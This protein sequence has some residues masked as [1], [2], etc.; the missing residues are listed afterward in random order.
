MLIVRKDNERKIRRRCSGRWGRSRR[1]RIQL[2]TC[3]GLALCY[4]SVPLFLCGAD[5]KV[6][7]S[8]WLVGVSDLSP[9][10]PATVWLAVQPMVS[11]KSVTVTVGTPHDATIS[12]SPT[13][14]VSCSTTPNNK[15]N[16]VAQTTDPL[17]LEYTVTA[18]A[19]GTLR[20]LALVEYTRNDGTHFGYAA[21]SDRM[22]VRGTLE[23]GP[24]AL[25]IASAVFGL[26]AGV[27]TQW[28]ASWRLQKQDDRKRQ[29]DE[30]LAASKL[31]QEGEHA[32]ITGLSVEL[33]K[34]HDVLE[35]YIQRGG[36]P[37]TLA[38]GS[39]NTL[40]KTAI[41]YLDVGSR[42]VYLKRIDAL[43]VSIHEYN[44]KVTT[45]ADPKVIR[46]AAEGLVAALVKGL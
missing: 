30:Q 18:H 6:P 2:S 26:V 4:L 27:L 32:L 29:L 12:V 11:A 24:T 3:V 45:T 36:T 34:N 39:Y 8:Q 42:A 19:T 14:G 25:P 5:E 28:F 17:L 44:S 33:V 35:E 23:I 7:Q 40:T 9:N 43:Y 13:Q 31:Q 20:M 38:V 37:P 41:G 15:I 10:K 22:V 21:L 16:C 46:S 1:W